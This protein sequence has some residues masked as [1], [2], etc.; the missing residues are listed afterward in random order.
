M[1]HFGN[2]RGSRVR[3]SRFFSFFL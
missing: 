3:F 1:L 2:L